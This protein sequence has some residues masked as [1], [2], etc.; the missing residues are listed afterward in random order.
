MRHI[1]L[2]PA[3]LCGSYSTEISLETVDGFGLTAWYAPAPTG[4]PTIV[5]FLGKSGSLRSQRYRLQ[6]FKVAN[7]GVLLL[8]YRGYSGNPGSPNEKG[9]YADA[10]S[11]IDWLESHGIDDRSI[12]L[13]GA[14]LGSG[15]ATEMALERRFAAVVLEAPYTSIAD[16]AALRLPIVPVRWLLK[17][18]FDSL[19]R[20]G[21]LTEP[22]LVM[23]GDG[24]SV[25]PQ[26]LGRALFTAA[27][28]RKEGFW[29]HGVGHNDIFDRGGF[30]AAL[31]F[32]ERSL[33]SYGPSGT[34]GSDVRTQ[35]SRCTIEQAGCIPQFERGRKPCMSSA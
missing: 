10:R 9:L 15:V 12:V 29:P 17:D 27:H 34:T 21:G 30:D 14:S 19:A 26:R 13:Y 28:T 6:H 32:I 18:R 8:A 2:A 25:I 35:H 1:K 16:V 20:M 31:N 5:M 24:D 3:T 7:M 22:L 33:R 4:R 11:A 23:H